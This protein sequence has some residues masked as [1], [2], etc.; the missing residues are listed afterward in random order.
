MQKLKEYKEIIIIVLVLIVGAFYWFQLR[1]IQIRKKCMILAQQ[2]ISPTIKDDSFG[3]NSA[4]DKYR[5]EKGIL[6]S[7]RINKLYF[8]CLKAKGLEI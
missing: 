3:E 7:E 5:A 4:I 1:P 2:G 6:S 8:L